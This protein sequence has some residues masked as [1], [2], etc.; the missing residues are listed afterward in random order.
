MGHARDR[1]D[2]EPDP[3]QGRLHLLFPGDE[4]SVRGALRSAMHALRA[5]EIEQ[6][7]TGVVEIVLAEVLNNVVEHAYASHGRGV[8]ELEVTQ[9]GD[10]LEFCIRDDG[11]PMPGET[12]PTGQVHDLDVA[13][14]DLP[15]GGFGWFMIR[16]LTQDLRYLRSGNRNELRFRMM[17][18][19]ATRPA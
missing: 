7:V 12:L 15:E 5:M 2:S 8:V 1:Q 18:A 6:D 10:M 19:A 9:V 11:A 13:P 3:G 16:E 4:G 14:D 17:S